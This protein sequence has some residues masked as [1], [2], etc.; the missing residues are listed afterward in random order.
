MQMLI[1]IFICMTLMFSQTAYSQSL[2]E[3]KEL[4]VD[5]HD[6]ITDYHYHR[7]PYKG[8]LLSTEEFEKLHALNWLHY[9]KK[10]IDNGYIINEFDTEFEITHLQSIEGQIVYRETREVRDV[11]GKVS[12]I[13]YIK[14]IISNE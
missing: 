12:N 4:Y 8:K 3:I 10:L 2:K 14:P 6:K 11:D 1:R 13:S 5:Y 9:D 7:K